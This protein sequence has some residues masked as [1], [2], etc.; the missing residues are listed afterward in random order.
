MTAAVLVL[1]FCAVSVLFVPKLRQGTAGWY[2]VM[3]GLFFACVKLAAMSVKSVFRSKVYSSFVA[4]FMTWDGI[5]YAWRLHFGQA[6]LFL[7]AFMVFSAFLS[8]FYA[9]NYVP[10]EKLGRF[11]ANVSGLVVSALACLGAKNMFQFVI[12]WDLS[13]LFAYMLMNTFHD[14]QSLRRSS[15]RFFIAHKV[16]DLPLFYAF[17]M[18]WEK[19]GMFF[20]PPFVS[21]YFA[22]F[23]GVEAGMFAVC[24]ILAAAAKLICFGFHFVMEDG[25]DMPV[26]A[27]AFCFPAVLSGLGMYLL[28]HCFP[29]VQDVP[30]VR[31]FFVAIGALSAAA[32]ILIALNVTY[33][34][35]IL[36]FILM[37]QFGFVTAAFGLSGEGVALNTFVA[38]AV[39]MIG[40]ILSAGNVIYA[41]WGEEDITRMGGL[42]KEKPFTLK[43]MWILSFCCVGFPY[44][45]TFGA[46]RDMYSAL[47]QADGRAF[48]FVFLLLSFGTAFAFARMMFYIFYAFPKTP[49][50]IAVKIRKAPLTGTI[51][52]ILLTIVSL[53]QNE[54]SK[55]SILPPLT[56]I[57]SAEVIFSSLLGCFGFLAGMKYFSRREKSQTRRSAVF[58]RLSLFC[59][60]GFGFSE[61]YRRLFAVPFLFVG[62]MLWLHADLDLI[63]RRL[64]DMMPAF[65]RKSAQALQSIHSGNLGL[66]FVWSIAGLLSLFVLGGVLAYGG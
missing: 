21:P 18:L 29:F 20:V 38:M 32:G 49:V 7:A 26:P 39:P 17:F 58:Q 63:E 56:G 31:T 50:E 4:P 13:A 54:L 60:K 61:L 41:L 52:L 9:K 55:R 47:F 12:G 65:V 66:S 45:G 27:A 48:T 19:T 37:S 62:N 57:L 35:A 33:V 10:S 6:E 15:V 34:K 30:N 25:S 28:Y 64:T 11:S 42:Q 44:I 3:I 1:L 5:S 36:S 51:P 59:A 14:K 40:L 22:S 16:T 23:S 8:L 46:R 24:I 43:I 2:L 53:F